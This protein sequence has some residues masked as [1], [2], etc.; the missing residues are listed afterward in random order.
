MDSCRIYRRMRQYL[1]QINLFE[2]EAIDQAT[3]SIQRWSTRIYLLLLFV[4]MSIIL[5]YNGIRLETRHYEVSNPSLEIYMELQKLYDTTLKCP[6]TQI[7]ILTGSFAEF[8]VE[9]DKICTSQFISQE[10]IDILFDN[11]TFRRFVVDFRATASNQF[12]VLRKLCDLSQATINN[13]IEIFYTER[14]IS[15]YLLSERLFFARGET[16]YTLLTYTNDDVNWYLNAQLNYFKGMKNLRYCTCDVN[17]TCYLPAGFYDIETIDNDGQVSIFLINASYTPNNWFMGCWP[18]ESLVLSSLTN[19]FLTNQST[20]NILAM[21]L[22]IPS[23]STPT[24]LIELEYAN[25]NKTFE[26]LIK[27]SFVNRWSPSLNYSAYF[28]QC[29]PQICTYINVQHSSFLYILASLLALYGGLSVV[30]RLLVPHMINFINCCMKRISKHE[31]ADNDDNNNNKDISETTADI[32]CSERFRTSIRSLWQL[33][34]HLNLFNTL[35]RQQSSDIKQQ[36]WMTRF[37]IISLSFTLAILIFYLLLRSDTKLIK[38][39]NPSLMTIMQ[40]QQSESN[41]LIS[42]LRCPCTQ[43]TVSYGSLVHLK[44]FYHQ[45][46]SSDFISSRWITTVARTIR[47]WDTPNYYRDFHN[48]ATLFQLLQSLCTFSNNTIISTLEKFE[49]IQLIT[50]D[51][52]NIDL[53]TNQM[54]SIIHQFKLETINEFRRFL[55]L[56]RNFTHVNQFL[57][58]AR[59]NF[60][61]RINASSPPTAAMYPLEHIYD[62]S[63]SSCACANDPSCK[64]TT[65]I[66]SG[67]RGNWI[68]HYTI[69][70]LYTACFPVESL[71]QSTLECFYDNNICLNYLFSYF[72]VSTLNNFT[73]LN[74]SSFASHYSINDSVGSIL[75]ELFIEYWN[76][77]QSYSAYFIQCQP[78]LCSY[79][80]SRR[81]TL[82][83][84]ITQI[85][86]LIGGLSVS[87]RFLTPIIIAIYINLTQKRR[88]QQNAPNQIGNRLGSLRS[89]LATLR[90]KIHVWIKEF[91]IFE[92]LYHTR[93]IYR[94]RAATRFYIV[95]LCTSLFILAIYTILTDSITTLTIQNPSLDEFQQLQQRYDSNAVN[96]PLCSSQFISESF[97]QELY[98]LY[99]QLDVSKAAINAFTLQD[100]ANDARE[101]FLASSFVSASMLE[102]QLFDKLIN[103]SLTNFLGTLPNSFSNSLRLIR[104]MTQA[105]SLVSAYTTNWYPVIRFLSDSPTIYLHPQHYG[106]NNCN[107][108]TL[109]TCTQAS[110]PFLPGYVVGCTPLES[111]L[112]SLYGGLS[113]FLKLAVPLILSALHKFKEKCNR[114][115]AQVHV[116]STLHN[117]D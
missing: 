72:N 50:A 53:F 42:S 69:P 103:A 76:G 6:C 113:T 97:L 56:M 54:L 89:R 18:L 67:T 21:H 78:T 86:S 11:V 108:A 2:T 95:G 47:A 63:S 22:K 62:N 24:A 111:I 58:G 110:A 93:N 112:R 41:G 37:Y 3:I 106:L 12:Q 9:Y 16:P 19:S 48:S 61:I 45:V 116:Q 38:V 105:N 33:V 92:N 35:L 84:V 40:F 71:L 109:S 25:E 98:R 7:S 94:E 115:I 29:Q 4:G 82:I 23:N 8:V 10:W 44:P 27:T 96:C 74:S 81:N 17:A 49:Q 64:V 104:G 55:Q 31:T 85:I 60:D 30:L 66:Y 14:L 88:H 87:L 36:R 32:S 114:N 91:N 68:D 80:I 57:T 77:S 51:L 26:Q 75:S 52:L 107:C 100:A 90:M 13:N 117:I 65:G 79:Q 15:D 70:G 34:V 99:N 59:S 102:F 1:L 39:V 46:C 28:T 73:R 83:E 101:K 5:I 43:L 20:L